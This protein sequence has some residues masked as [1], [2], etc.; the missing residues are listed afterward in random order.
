MSETDVFK[1]LPGTSGWMRGDLLTNLQKHLCFLVL[2]NPESRAVYDVF[3]TK[4]LGVKME[5]NKSVFR[6]NAL[7]M[8]EQLNVSAGSLA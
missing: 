5:V 2:A 6:S 1:N 7:L 3:G 4:A 8:Y